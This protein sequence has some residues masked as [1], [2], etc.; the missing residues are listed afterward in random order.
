[1]SEAP[2][3]GR[4]E[5]GYVLFGVLIGATL[6]GIGLLAAVNLWSRVLQRE[7]EAE[8]V[9]RG[10]AVVRAIERF[11][12]DRPGA[13]PESL[14][15][16]VEGGYLRRVWSDPVTR[17]PF[18][19]LRPSPNPN[20]AGP[21]GAMTGAMAGDFVEAAPAGPTEPGAVPGILG[22]ASAS[23]ELSLRIYEGA[24]RYSDWRF[25]AQPSA[26]PGPSDPEEEADP[27]P[28]R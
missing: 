19:L 2:E 11:Q 27:G 8:L 21:P 22:V 25:E 1:M 12:R 26:A 23:D 20:P 3:R 14:E 10:E 24:R 9:F 5:D 17:G 7:Q 4:R 6:L 13:L 15:E 16:L 18:R 28:V